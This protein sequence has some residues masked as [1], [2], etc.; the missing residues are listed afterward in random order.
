MVEHRWPNIDELIDAVGSGEHP[1]F[2]MRTKE[3]TV[4]P[5]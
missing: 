1:T 3:M 5:V 2:A 4:L